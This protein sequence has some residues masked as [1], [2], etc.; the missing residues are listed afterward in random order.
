MRFFFLQEEPPAAG[1]SWRPPR[2]L[3]RHLAEWDARH[4]TDPGEAPCPLL[5]DGACL[6]YEARPVLCRTHGF[7]LRTRPSGD[8]DSGEEGWREAALESF[9]RAIEA[10]PQLELDPRTTSPKV[11]HALHAARAARGE[12]W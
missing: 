10:D 3:A 12:P 4:G 7:P 9:L 6:L 2:A 11:L 8:P 5:R 1:G